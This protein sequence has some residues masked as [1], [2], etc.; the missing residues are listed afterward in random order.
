MLEKVCGK[1]A[2]ICSGGKISVNR[3]RR[4]GLDAVKT[5]I[6]SFFLTSPKLVK[7]AILERPGMPFFPFGAQRRH[8]T[9]PIFGDL[10]LRGMIRT[11]FQ[12]CKFEKA[13]C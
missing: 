7:V 8:K 3:E 9:P 10:S 1:Q 4:Y 5:A 2:V 11:M 13:V 12:T 6:F